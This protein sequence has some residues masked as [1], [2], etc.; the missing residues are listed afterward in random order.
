MAGRIAVS[1]TDDEGQGGHDDAFVIRLEQVNHRYGDTTALD[2]VSLAVPAGRLAGLIGPDGVGKSTLL[3]LVA[4][5]RRLQSGRIEVLGLDLGDRHQRRSLRPDIAYMAQG[6]GTNLYPDLSVTENVDFFGRLFGL[7]PEARRER[8]AELLEATGLAPFA[9]RAARKLSGGMRQK[10]GLC[11]ALVHDPRLLV[12]DEPTTG[13][14]PLSRRQFWDLLERIRQRRSDMSVLVATAYMEEAEGF[15]WLGVLHEG[16]VVATGSPREIQTELEVD[17]LEAAYVALVA[18]DL[19]NGRDGRDDGV[20]RDVRGV[21]DAPDLAD[22]RDSEDRPEAGGGAETVGREDEVAVEARELTRRF[23]D[24]TAVDRVS[25]EIRRGEIFGF[26]GSN[27]S[28]KTTT[29]KMLTGLLP[30]SEGEARLFGRELDARD[31]Q[32]RRRVGFMSQS[33]SL[34]RELSVRQNLE[35]HARLYLDPAADEADPGERIEAALDRFELRRVADEAAESLPLGVRQRLSL[36]VAVIHR[37]ELLILDEPTSGVDPMA[38]DAFWSEL[39]ALSRR[40]GVTIFLSTHFMNE[41]E[42]C[43]RLALMHEGRVLATGS[44]GELMHELGADSLEEAF[45]GALEAEAREKSGDDEASESAAGDGD[46]TARARPGAD[47]RPARPPRL[48]DP[49]RA[50][51]ITNREAREI[52][53]DPIRLAFALI[54]PALLLL[55]DGY[56]ISFDV[57][58]LAFAVLDRDQS[59]ESRRYLESFRGSRYFR[60]RRPLRDEDDLED[61]LRS[62]EL[63]LALEIPDGFGRE[64]WRG[65]QPE[66]GIWLDG[67]MPFKAE[68]TRGY[69]QGLH[70]GFVETHWTRDRGRDPPRPPVRIEPRF[71]YNQEFESVQAIVPGVIMLILVLIPAIMTAVGVVREKELGSIANFYVT[72]TTRLEFML[73]KQLPYIGVG[74]LGF[75]VMLTLTFFVFRVPVEGSLIALSIGALLYVTATTALGLL[76]STFVRTQLAAIFATAILT[77]LPATQFSGLLAPVSSL[78]G[79]AWIFGRGFPSSWFQQVSIGTFA[80]GLGT[81]DLL[82]PYAALVGFALLYLAGACALLRKQER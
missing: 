73:G 45:V 63:A 5:T 50:W 1:E 15:D 69:V 33:F 27:G 12:L 54:A 36:A 43:D 58:D 68:T 51:A 6:L 79:A 28:G 29:M 31:G 57:E 9:D 24:F 42:R 49:R 44:P 7:A 71:R 8:I 39:I 53:R 48:F 4:G 20:G 32:T 81:S 16:R 46:R 3:G 80:K 55:A 67:A 72:P 66:V 75:V 56:G 19:H 52:V 38:R 13:V 26:V 34:Y 10:L 25:F 70:A 59:L 23:G 30:A 65:E 62:G 76:I 61:R 40:E 11:C 78:S 37:P 47:E 22:A 60:E 82:I 2:G 18:P 35:L 21:R 64:L 74:G 14:D 77:T 17:S 41:A